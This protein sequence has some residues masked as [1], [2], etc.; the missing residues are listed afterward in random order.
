MIVPVGLY[1][2]LVGSIRKS[3]GDHEEHM[4]KEEKTTGLRPQI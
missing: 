3:W 4:E 2:A 1:A